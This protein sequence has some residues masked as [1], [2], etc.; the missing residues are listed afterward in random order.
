MKLN[1][2]LINKTYMLD[3]LV[4]YQDSSLNELRRRTFHVKVPSNLTVKSLNALLCDSHDGVFEA[5]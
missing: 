5:D 1:K 4:Q 3:L 2:S